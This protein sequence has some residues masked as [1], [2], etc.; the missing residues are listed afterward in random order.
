MRDPQ[1]LH[2]GHRMKSVKVQSDPHGD[3]GSQAEMTWPRSWL[4]AANG[5][6]TMPKVGQHPD[7]PGCC[8]SVRRRIEVQLAICWKSRVSG[9]TRLE[10]EAVTIRRCGQSAG[11]AGGSSSGAGSEDSKSVVGESAEPLDYRNPQRPYAS[12]LGSDAESKRWSE[13]HGDMGSN[14]SE[15]PCRVSSDLHEWRNDL[16]TV[17]TRDPAKLHDE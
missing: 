9:G 11:K 5:V 14:S 16:A 15:I 8:P 13:P 2:A 4:L 12:Q 6:T 10:F 3:M 1:R 17:S 7:V